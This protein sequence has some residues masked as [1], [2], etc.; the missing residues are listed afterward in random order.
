VAI[1]SV[2]AF[3]F[4]QVCGSMAAARG[5]AP[6]IARIDA[7]VRSWMVR[8]A[9]GA[10]HVTVLHGGRT[11]LERGYGSVGPG[12]GPPDSRS[13]FPIGSIS[14]QFT[15]AAIVALADEGR[16]R[17]DAPAGDL[18]PEWFA[19]EPG[20]R[21]SH[22]LTHTS[23]IADFLW[24]DGYRRLADDPATPASAFVALAAAAPRRFEPG[25]RWAYSNTNYKALALV[26]ERAAGQPFDT[27]LAE[28]VLRPPG[29]AGIGPCH[30]LG[31]GGFVAGYA[32]T[33]KLA[34]LDASRAAYAGDGGLC[35]SAAGLV[36]WLRKGPVDREG[37]PPR[38]ARLA[39]PTRLRSGRVV[40]YGFGL[41]TREFLGH[42][43]IWHAGNVDGH[44]ALVAH[45]PEDDRSIVVL[46]NKGFVW[47]TELLPDWI[48]EPAPA[49]ARSTVEPPLGRFEDGLFRYAIR[50]DG[51][52]LRVAIDLIGPLTFVPAGASEYLARDYP[53]TFRIRLPTDGSRD[54]FEIDW[55]EVQ[56]FAHRVRDP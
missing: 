53:A 9:V 51:D 39:V 31:P 30:D 10:A 14:K 41:S 37:V 38:L 15:A 48:G 55:G 24:L 22:L 25:E 28:R 21:V 18:L 33:G 43:M 23:G 46:T 50:A 26:A 13:V 36:D 45:A 11:V 4:M 47:L 49:P 12:S 35:A 20:L 29:V 34:P 27:V 52:G 56:S 44:S 40:P 1:A 8:E 16:L 17:L 7:A 42:R 54:S 2:V 5:S 19:A 3:T 32:P 6:D